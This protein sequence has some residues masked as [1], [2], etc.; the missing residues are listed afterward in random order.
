[1]TENRCYHSKSHH[2]ATVFQIP[3][4]AKISATSRSVINVPTRELLVGE[5]K[6]SFVKVLNI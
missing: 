2:T 5:T 6:S 3:F 4:I 1:M